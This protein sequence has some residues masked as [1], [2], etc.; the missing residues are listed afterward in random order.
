M[1]RA[2]VLGSPISHSL[3]PVIHNRAYAELG[4]TGKF[5]AIEVK[6]GELATFLASAKSDASWRGFSLTMPLK[7]EIISLADQVDPIA[8]RIGSANFA[9][10]SGDDSHHLSVRSTDTYGFEWVYEKCKALGKEFTSD[11][12]VCVIGAGA[13][14]RA[15]L[16]ALDGR[17]AHVDVISRSAHRSP[18]LERCLTKTSLTIRTWNELAIAF[19]HDV[20]INT[21]PYVT[22]HELIAAMKNVG[23]PHGA[24]IDAIYAPAPRETLSAWR[25]FGLP[26][27]DGLDLL[28][29]QALPQIHEMTERSFDHKEMFAI[30]R[31]EV[32]GHVNP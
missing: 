19:A 24:F 10:Y 28:I 6:S 32:E 7:E 15:A 9:L 23:S 17:V 20:I 16:Y 29:A 5:E 18:A 11:T 27:I 25:K 1:I 22:T 31:K 14:A 30:L 8:Q 3:S 26:V 2:A 12:K 4:I 13:T 21:T